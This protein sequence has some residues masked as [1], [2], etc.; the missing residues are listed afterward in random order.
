MKVNP[1]AFANNGLQ[2]NYPEASLNRILSIQNLEEV[3]FS[4]PVKQFV[5]SKHA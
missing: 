5:F 3:Y 4:F 1:K 2:K